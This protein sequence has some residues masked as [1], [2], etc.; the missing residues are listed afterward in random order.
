MRHSLWAFCQSEIQVSSRME[1]PPSDN[2]ARKASPT[3]GCAGRDLASRGEPGLWPGGT[4]I[5]MALPPPPC[6]AVSL[7][8]SASLPWLRVCRGR[9]AMAVCWRVLTS[10]L[11]LSS[12]R[13]ETARAARRGRGHWLLSVCLSEPVLSAARAGASRRI[14]RRDIKAVYVGSVG[15]RRPARQMP[16]REVPSDR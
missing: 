16:L 6:V 14:R 13:S 12:A 4:S 10:E 11:S 1:N 2:V 15:R 9:T 3:Q 8:R 5:S 7:G